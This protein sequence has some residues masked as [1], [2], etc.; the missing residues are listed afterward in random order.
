M[1][2]KSE[3]LLLLEML[4]K[5]RIRKEDQNI[6]KSI[7]FYETVSK[8]KDFNLIDNKLINKKNNNVK[9]YYLS[10]PNGWCLANLLSYHKNTPKQYRDI[11]KEFIVI[12]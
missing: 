11:S 5:K 8:L 7:K 9:Y 6:Y 3:Q 2:T 12:P 10:F 1:L 4:L